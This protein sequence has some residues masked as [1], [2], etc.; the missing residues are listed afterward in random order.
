MGILLC[1]LAL[2]N[3]YDWI[4]SKPWKRVKPPVDVEQNETRLED[5]SFEKHQG[6]PNSLNNEISHA[7]TTT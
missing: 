7:R 5:E 6:D 3:F 2:N 1:L 4:R